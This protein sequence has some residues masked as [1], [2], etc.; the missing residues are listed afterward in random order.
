MIFLSKRFILISVLTMFQFACTNVGNLSIYIALYSV[1]VH[2][3][4]CVFID[5][6][7][8]SH[9]STVTDGD[10]TRGEICGFGSNLVLHFLYLCI[11]FSNDFHLRLV[12]VENRK[13]FNDKWPWRID[14]KPITE[15]SSCVMVRGILRW[16]VSQNIYSYW[17]VILLKAIFYFILSLHQV[18]MSSHV[19]NKN[20]LKDIVHSFFYII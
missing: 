3:F 14:W 1:S 2:S 5:W 18:D 7:F 11:L 20:C 4:R 17:W 9:P 16:K 10:R 12:M 19:T 13:W 15:Q 6:A 8:R